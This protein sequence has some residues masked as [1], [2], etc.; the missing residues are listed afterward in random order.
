MTSIAEDYQ[1]LL[2]EFLDGR[3]SPLEFQKRYLDKFKREDRQMDRPTFRVLDRLFG[4][5]D[6]FTYDSVLVS[7]NADFYVNEDQLRRRVT[8]TIA[9]LRM[10][11]PL[12]PPS[13]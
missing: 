6:A 5:V 1:T 7:M 4:D 2:Q 10:I 11:V 12:P 13:R 8:E 3:I 9:N